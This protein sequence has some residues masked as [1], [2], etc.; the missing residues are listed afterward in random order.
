MAELAQIAVAADAKERACNM[1]SSRLYFPASNVPELYHAEFTATE[2]SADVYLPSPVSPEGV[3]PASLS[4]LH[5][6]H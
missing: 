4:A 3:V 5:P 2:C 1:E 6:N